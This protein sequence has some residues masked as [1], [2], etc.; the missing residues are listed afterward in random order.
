MH[1]SQGAELASE[2]R[3]VISAGALALHRD[4]EGVTLA[5]ACLRL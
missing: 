5:S 1:L 3:M 4:F 2:V